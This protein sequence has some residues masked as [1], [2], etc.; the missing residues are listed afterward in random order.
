MSTKG[1]KASVGPASSAWSAGASN[2][3]SL[4]FREDSSSILSLSSRG[5]LTTEN[6]ISASARTDTPR[7]RPFMS[8]VSRATKVSGSSGSFSLGGGPPFLAL[9]SAL[10][11]ASAGWASCA[12]RR[13]R[14]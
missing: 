9:G 12:R 1:C 14:H 2:T 13:E 11:G 5:S 8:M 4:T 6:G 3:D 7:S 10:A